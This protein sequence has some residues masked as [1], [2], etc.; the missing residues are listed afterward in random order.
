MRQDNETLALK[1]DA[2]SR[3]EFM[4]VALSKSL[5]RAETVVSGRHGTHFDVL[6]LKIK[7]K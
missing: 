7:E 3:G 2:Q 5:S 4:S 6:I 1:I